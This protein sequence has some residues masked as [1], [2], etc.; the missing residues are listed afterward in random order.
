ML[1]LTTPVILTFNEGPNLERTLRRLYWAT[2]IV[3]VDSG[4]T[5][6]TLAIA[7]ANTRVRL[8]QRPFESHSQQWKFATEETGI[9]TPWILRLDADYEM[10]ME[11]VGEIAQLDPEAKVDAYSIAFDYA[12]YSKKL[13]STLYPPNTILL[14]R[15]AFAIRNAGH[16][17]RWDVAGPVAVLRTRMVH[18]DWKPMS[19]WVSS[20]ARYMERELAAIDTGEG[21]GLKRR[22]R[23]WLRRHPPLMPI[24]VFIYCL[25]GRGLVFDGRAGMLYA[26]QRTI[27]E[28]IFSLLYLESRLRRPSAEL[29]ETG[30]PVV[31]ASEATAPA[32]VAAPADRRRAQG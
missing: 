30:R 1:D 22:L 32:A 10:P 7:R 25:F 31:A 28:S 18:D 14:R 5:D 27:A 16:T 8:F 23:N 9:R 19:A 12:V 21:G 2:D 17:E 15:G 13:A 11:L 20:Q 3:I 29:Q 26:L 24:A 6:E 4:S